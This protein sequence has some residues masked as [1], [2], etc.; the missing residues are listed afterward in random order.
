[1]TPTTGLAGD[2]IRQQGSGVVNTDFGPWGG[3]RRRSG[4]AYIWAGL[5]AVTRADRDRSYSPYA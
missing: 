5:R 4:A 1:M 2:G 3:S